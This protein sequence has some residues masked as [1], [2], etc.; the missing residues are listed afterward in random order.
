[1]QCSTYMSAPATAN[2]FPITSPL[3]A[4]LVTMRP[5]PAFPNG[6]C[7][8]VPADFLCTCPPPR[9]VPEAAVSKNTAAPPS[10]VPRPGFSWHDPFAAHGATGVAVV[11]C[12]HGR[13][14]AK[15]RARAVLVSNT[16][17][18][19]CAC[20]TAAIRAVQDHDVRLV[21]R[22]HCTGTIN[23]P[24]ALRHSC[25]T[26]GRVIRLRRKVSS[27]RVQIWPSQCCTTSQRRRAC[28]RVCAVSKLNHAPSLRSLLQRMCSWR[29]RRRLGQ[30]P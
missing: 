11:T 26:T 27:R 1:M 7:A 20:D 2:G 6:A 25:N 3:P 17:P 28:N 15:R 22:T 4:S 23:R 9:V 21:S 13:T 19:A 10:D 30:M 5:P 24:H 14:E 8:S 12:T 18:R 16:G 29:R